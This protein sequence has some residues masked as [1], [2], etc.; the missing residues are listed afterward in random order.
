MLQL[1]TRLCFIHFQLLKGAP[2]LLHLRSK[3]ELFI[4]VTDVIGWRNGSLS[5]SRKSPYYLLNTLF[6]CFNFCYKRMSCKAD[7][8]TMVLCPS[9]VLEQLPGRRQGQFLFAC[10]GEWFILN[11]VA[12]FALFVLSYVKELR[13]TWQHGVDSV[14]FYL[15]KV[16]SSVRSMSDKWGNLVA[17]RAGWMDA[18]EREKKWKLN[19]STHSR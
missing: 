12:M 7:H 11:G 19:E 15:L 6:L 5:T 14:A 17:A 13:S 9:F 16:I 3:S 10:A 1:H 2:A 18:E 8:I 4:R